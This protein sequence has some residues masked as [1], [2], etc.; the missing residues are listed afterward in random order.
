MIDISIRERYADHEGGTKFYRSML[1]SSSSSPYAVVLNNFGPKDKTG[2]F[3]L[4]KMTRDEAIKKYTSIIDSKTKRGYRFKA[5][6]E[7]K[8][9]DE[10]FEETGHAVTTAGDHLRD[11]IAYIR[12]GF[13][14][15]A[16]PAKPEAG[17]NRKP[18]VVEPEPD[19]GPM[20]GSW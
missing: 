6:P 5:A 7:S 2:Q 1:I 16:P 18:K 15:I 11:A 8:F 13:E 4:L 12:T 20:W 10:E 14:D 9:N 3:Q 19:R 17:R